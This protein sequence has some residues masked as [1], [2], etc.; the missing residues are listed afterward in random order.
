MRTFVKYSPLMIAKHVS[1]FFKGSF[2]IAEQGTS[3][4]FDGGKV[5]IDQNSNELQRKVGKEV[6]KIIAGFLS[7]RPRNVSYE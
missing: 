4:K 1:S 6:N 3:F 5:L 2:E 7:A